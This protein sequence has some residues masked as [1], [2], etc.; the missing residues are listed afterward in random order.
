MSLVTRTGKGSQ[1]TQAEMDANL[2]EIGAIGANIASATTTDL[3]NATGNRI[4]I[5][6]TTTITS[7]GTAA[8]QGTLRLVRFQGALTLT[9]NATNLILPLAANLTTR[10]GD[11][12][13]VQK[14]AAAGADGWRVL[15]LWRNGDGSE[16]AGYVQFP[17]IFDNGN[18]GAT[19]TIDPTK[20]ARQKITANTA[21]ITT[22]TITAPPNNLPTTLHI[23]IYQD[24][25]GSRAWAVGGPVGSKW[26]AGADKVLSTAASARDRLVADYD[27]ANWV[28][29]LMKGIA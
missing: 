17:A 18:S 4:D 9:H 2:K 11:I 28:C 1:L 19:P 29:Q 3:N 21:S 13:W 27:G 24:A 5:T 25:T 12:V 6:G 22:F 16:L 23:D 20:G 10:A 26:P 8:P 14:E 7:F 15:D